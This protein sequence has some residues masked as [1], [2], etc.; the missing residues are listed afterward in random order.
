VVRD[1]RNP[2]KRRVRSGDPESA[3]F[4]SETQAVIVV[5]DSSSNSPD[6]ARLSSLP[7]GHPQGYAQCFEAFVADTY[8]A[9]R[10]EVRDGLPTFAD[11]ARTARIVEAVVLSAA[12]NSWKDIA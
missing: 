8:A 10:G 1:R 3:W 6:A 9:V 5:R 12:T 7:A 11:A 2:P 4:G